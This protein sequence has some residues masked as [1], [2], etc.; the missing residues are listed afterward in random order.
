MSRSLVVAV[1]ILALALP[2]AASAAPSLNVVPQKRCYSSGETVNLMGSEFSP[3]TSVSITRDDDPVGVLNTNTAGAFNGELTLGQSRGTQQ[4]TYTATDGTN[5]SI[6]ASAQI[7]VSAVRVKVQ[8]ETGSPGRRLTITAAGFTTGKT[9]WAH[10]VR[11]KSRRH[12][13]IGQLK[14]ACGKLK[15][16]KRLLRESAPFGVY[17]IQF[18]TYRKYNPRRAVRD[19]YTITVRPG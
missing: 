11:G 17:T 12:V 5:G 19:R 16:R 13:R 10:I 2:S 6:T 1:V 8:P 7:T 15:A 18:D 3:S 9:L 14:R 4:R